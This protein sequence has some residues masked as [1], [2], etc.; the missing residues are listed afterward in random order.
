M[1][2]YED[3]HIKNMLL[4]EKLLTLCDATDML[5]LELVVEGC[6]YDDIAN[7]TFFIK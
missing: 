7:K 6:S 3:P 4:V 1:F 5:I 2:F